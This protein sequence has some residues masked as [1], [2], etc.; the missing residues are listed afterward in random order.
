MNVVD[1]AEGDEALDQWT[2]LLG[3]RQRGDDALLIDQRSELVAK[4]GGAMSGRPAQLAVDHSMSHVSIT[5]L[6]VS[7]ADCYSRI[8]APPPPLIPLTPPSTPINPTTPS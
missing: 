5:S 4:Q 7:R 2:E 1:A 8:S 6:V 3:L